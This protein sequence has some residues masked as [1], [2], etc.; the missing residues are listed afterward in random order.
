[1]WIGTNVGEDL[2]NEYRKK[3]WVEAGWKKI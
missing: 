2:Q 3:E 1:M